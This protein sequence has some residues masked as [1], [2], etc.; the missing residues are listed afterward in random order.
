MNKGVE[1]TLKLHSIQL[2]TE[3]G[4]EIL[5]RM[6]EIQLLNHFVTINQTACVKNQWMI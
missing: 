2:F 5:E 3:M 1:K 6:D 4:V